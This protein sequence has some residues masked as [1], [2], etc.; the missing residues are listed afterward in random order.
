M[1]PAWRYASLSDD[2]VEASILITRDSNPIGLRL[3]FVSQHNAFGL[4][5][6]RSSW[7]H[8]S[9]GYRRKY[10]WARN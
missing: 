10:R 1:I 4:G 2:V 7:N 9:V 6:D 8:V 3:V 5:D